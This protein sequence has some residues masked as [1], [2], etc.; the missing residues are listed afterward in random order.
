MGAIQSQ[1]ESSYTPPRRRR[2][3]EKKNLPRVVLN[4]SDAD[5]N[6]KFTEENDLTVSTLG[7]CGYLVRSLDCRVTERGRSWLY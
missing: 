7:G 3:A 4:Q 1:V 6:L 2:M 5:F